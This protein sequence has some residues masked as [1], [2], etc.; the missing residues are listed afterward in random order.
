MTQLDLDRLL[1]LRLVVAR[2]GEMDRAKWW[3]TKGVLGR[4]G[5]LLLG[6]GFPR[7]HRF[8][9][10]RLVFTVAKARCEEY[11]TAPGTMTLWTLPADLEDQFDARWHDWLDDRESWAEFF[12]RLEEL[13]SDDLVENLRSFELVDDEVASAVS[14]MRR[15]AEGRAVPLSGTF[16]P[17]DESLTLLAA[18]FARGEPGKPAVPHA[19]LAG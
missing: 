4:Q 8:T 19:R 10:A 5:R 14:Q 9:Q 13:P 15:S 18:A 6:R 17:T 11:F 3:N 1:R 2:H 16:E 12:D 7:T